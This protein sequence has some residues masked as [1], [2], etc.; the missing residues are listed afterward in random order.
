MLEYKG[1]KISWLGHSGF[2]IRNKKTVCIDPF[3][4]RRP[5]IADIL[6]ITHEHY[7]HCSIEDINKIATEYTFVVTT[8]MCKEKL[9]RLKLGQIKTVRPGDRF[10]VDDVRIE[11][12]PAYNIN[13]FRTPS[14]PF[15]PKE[16]GKLGF[17][18]TI[19]GVKIYHAGDTDAIPEM[20]DLTPDIALLPV[21]GTYVMTADEAIEAVKRIKP[22][23]AIPMHYGNIVGSKS[24]AEKFKSKASCEVYILEQE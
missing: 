3:Q 7:D 22:K 11:V 19:S 1:I 2:V 15:H 16:D 6:L 10:A 13:K 8:D 14:R 20:K 18:I 4:I 23:I 21:S 24:D 9:S 12:V 17:M 5:F